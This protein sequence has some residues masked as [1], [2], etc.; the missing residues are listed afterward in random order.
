MAASLLG[1]FSHSF[2]PSRPDWGLRVRDAQSSIHLLLCH[3][4]STPNF[5]ILKWG[6]YPILAEG[7]IKSHR[8]RGW[9]GWGGAY[10]HEQLWRPLCTCSLQIPEVWT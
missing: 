5:L 8:K 6:N 9:C 2:P 4:L 10:K 1:R 7:S 3:R